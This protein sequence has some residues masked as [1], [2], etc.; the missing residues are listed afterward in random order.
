MAERNSLSPALVKL[1]RVSLKETRLME[2][3]KTGNII[4][5][6]PFQQPF[7]SSSSLMSEPTSHNA[8]LPFPASLAAKGEKVMLF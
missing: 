4:G 6:L 1:S 3:K 7:F 5:G 2:I 8:R